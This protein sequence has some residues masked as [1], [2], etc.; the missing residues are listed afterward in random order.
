LT[1]CDITGLGL[2]MISSEPSI[3]ATAMSVSNVF[4]L[5]KTCASPIPIARPMLLWNLMTAS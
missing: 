4:G 5:G 2:A 1:A 3:A